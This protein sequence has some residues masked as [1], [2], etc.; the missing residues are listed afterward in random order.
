MA[1]ARKNHSPGCRRDRKCYYVLYET[2]CLYS[3]RFHRTWPLIAG[4]Y[5]NIPGEPLD[6]S[7]IDITEERLTIPCPSIV[8]LSLDMMKKPDGVL[9]Y[10]NCLLRILPGL[11]DSP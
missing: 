9:R 10:L 6:S 1:Q 2:N 11:N 3:R 5:N 7:E 8:S 4:V